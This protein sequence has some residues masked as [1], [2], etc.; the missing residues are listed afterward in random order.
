MT[1]PPLSLDDAVTGPLALGTCLGGLATLGV[2]QLIVWR[3]PWA[4]RVNRAILDWREPT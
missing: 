4:R 2:W 1:I 3:Y